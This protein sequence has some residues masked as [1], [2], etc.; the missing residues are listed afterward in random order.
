MKKDVKGLNDANKKG[1]AFFDLDYTLI[2]HDTQ[3][4]FCNYVLRKKPV[5]VFYTLFFFPALMLGALRILRS[6]GLKKT[7]LSFLWGISSNELDS[8][9]SAFVKEEVL[10]AIYPDL[11]AELEIHKKEGRVTILN[12]ASPE[13][14]ARHIAKELGFDHYRATVVKIGNRMPLLPL[15]PER[16]NKRYVKLVSMRELLPKEMKKNIPEDPKQ[17][18]KS[19]TNGPKIPNSYAYSDSP[20]DLPMLEIAENVTLV[21]PESSDL[22]RL[23]KKNGW[24]ILHPV[25]PYK[26]SLENHLNNLKQAFGLYKRAAKK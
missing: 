23:A 9:A 3:L 13:I 20:A 17:A 15:F 4:L 22:L 5:R 1:F 18:E 12:T 24:R 7:F 25:R 19:D 8:L 6:E 14:Y 10:P 11:L 2:P 21:H 26:N 16:N